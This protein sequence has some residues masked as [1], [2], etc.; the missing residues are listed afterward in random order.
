MKAYGF[1][2]NHLEAMRPLE[3]ITMSIYATEATQQFPKTRQ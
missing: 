2:A 1:D 3:E